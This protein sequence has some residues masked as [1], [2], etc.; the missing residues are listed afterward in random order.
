[1]ENAFYK[2]I[3]GQRIEKAP[4]PLSVLCQNIFTNSEKIH[5]ENGYYKL[6]K[7]DYPNDGNLYSAVYEL[8]DKVIY[9]SWQIAEISVEDKIAQLKGL[10]SNT[11][12]QAIKYA[13][14]WLT[15]D[16]YEPLKAQRQTWRDEINRLEVQVH[17]KEQN[18]E[19]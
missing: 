11:D 4:V 14:G 6:V 7:A 18:M 9:M 15:D 1:M 12:Y 5:N 3:D 16:E 13:E 17:E 10:L 8:K 19:V 2:F